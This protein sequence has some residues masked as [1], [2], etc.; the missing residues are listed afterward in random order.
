MIFQNFAFVILFISWT[1]NGLTTTMFDVVLQ[2]CSYVSQTFNESQ[3]AILRKQPIFERCKNWNE[4]SSLTSVEQLS[5][6]NKENIRCLLYFETLNSTCKYFP[7]L[8]PQ[9]I[10]S[11]AQ[12]ISVATACKDL[13][14]LPK[15]ISEFQHIHSIITNEDACKYLCVEYRSGVDNLNNVCAKSYYLNNL[16]LDEHHDSESV[17][18]NNAVAFSENHNQDNTQKSSDEIK[19]QLPRNPDESNKKPIVDESVIEKL[20]DN[21]GSDKNH[22][23]N[24]VV[25]QILEAQK[26]L[27]TTN[28]AKLT[29]DTNSLK[30]KVTIAQNQKLDKNSGEKNPIITEDQTDKKSSD[31]D[32]INPI[33]APSHIE[34]NNDEPQNRIPDVNDVEESPKLGSDTNIFTDEPDSIKMDVPNAGKNHDKDN[35]MYPDDAEKYEQPEIEENQDILPHEEDTPN[36]LIGPKVSELN[37][38]YGDMDGNSHFFTYFSFICVVFVLGY[39][40]YHNKQKVLAILLEGRISKRPQRGRRPNSANYHK[41]DSNLEEAISSSCSKNTSHIIY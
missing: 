38:D 7:R 33:I 41:L 16:V 23:S 28:N 32:K 40:G 9:N 15:P 27:S 25:K 20:T 14:L 21:K 26:S 13:S 11:E 30:E 6:E 10:F 24:A 36:K 2:N 19:L 12:D 3:L 17:P 18:Q 37:E 4:I 5:E 22:I 1:C 29:D 35:N 34:A 31:K 39:I 8:Q